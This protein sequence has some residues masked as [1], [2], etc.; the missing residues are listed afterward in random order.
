MGLRIVI[1][2][3]G[4]GK[5]MASVMPKVLHN[6][7]GTSL[8]ERVVKTARSLSP[9]DIC[10]IHGNGGSTVQD[11]LN[12]LPVEWI[13]QQEQLGTGHAVMQAIPKYNDSD[14]V[15]ILY[16]DVPLISNVTLKRLL[17]DTPHNGLGLIVTESQS[18]AGFGRI[19][20]NEMGNIIAI[21]EHQD[22]NPQQLEIKEINT[23]ILT[24]SAKQLKSWLP[25]LQNHNRQKEYYLTDVV[26]LA[27]NDGFPVGGIHAH[28]HEEVQGVNDR[29]QL[30]KLER[31]Y[32]ETL[33]QQL[34]LTGV[35][36]MDP[37]RLDIRG[38][39]TMGIDVVVDVNVI[40]EGKVKIGCN[41]KIG[42]NVILKDVDIGDEVE[43]FA[44]SIIEGATI[45]KGAQIGPFARIRPESTIEENAKVGNFVEMKK[46]TLGAN[47]KASHLTYLG[48]AN[49]GKNVNIGAG[50]ITC[51]YDGV[52]KHQT[53]IE[54]DV[55]I[56]SNTSLIAPVKIGKKA[57]VGAG[58][59]ISQEAPPD[60]LT[61]TRAKQR[62]VDGWQRPKKD[63]K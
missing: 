58:S 42:P 24:A 2:A 51:N 48:D 9:D 41:C 38:E 31:H 60:M 63:N 14:Q 50:T 52:N 28:G 54:D 57:T 11:E 37:S 59:T 49:I 13:K 47:S 23:G 12:Y 5:R 22:A 55:F 4:K 40:L 62:T 18:P 30:T 21:V 10:V 32:Q 1:L 7:G 6:L 34:A 19:I 25:R 26:A 17:E 20:R 29:W 53:E 39:V 33:A 8:L 3:A 44:N 43:I 15:L 61:L 16:G 36:I 27:V 46:S 56:G 45:A 35:T